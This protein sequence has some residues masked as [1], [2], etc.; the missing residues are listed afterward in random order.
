M[1]RHKK[2]LHKYLHKNLKN[3]AML[4]L[5]VVLGVSLL[6]FQ[7]QLTGKAVQ[8]SRVRD[9]LKCG[10]V[11]TPKTSSP[12][13][14]TDNDP[15][16]Q[17]PCRNGNGLKITGFNKVIDC[18]GLSITSS[19]NRF[20]GIE[21]RSSGNEIKNCK[22]SGF[23]SGIELGHASKNLLQNNIL[24]NSWSLRFTGKSKENVIKS[25]F[26]EGEEADILWET[27]GSKNKLLGNDFFG[28]KSIDFRKQ[29]VPQICDGT[30][31]NY[32]ASGVEE[33]L[34]LQKKSSCGISKQPFTD[35][36]KRRQ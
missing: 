29:Q 32:L 3:I 7:G 10:D 6:F 12:I 36:G 5:F 22:I 20:I 1:D 34:Q 16:T 21:V 26:F 30:L 4:A 11:I 17:A 8:D 25:N 35:E 27:Y 15:I 14:L 28:T 24:E 33:P 18:K 19:T 31:G 13:V 2:H 23:E 9:P